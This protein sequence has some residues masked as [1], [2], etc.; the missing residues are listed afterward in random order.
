MTREASDREDLLREAKALVD[1]IKLVPIGGRPDEHVITG[2][3]NNGATS[4]CFGTDTV[5]HFSAGGQ[6]RRAHCNAILFKASNGKLV[7]S[8]S[9]W[10][11]GHNC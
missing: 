5:Y 7:S 3:R 8:V 4:F 1:R 9:G 2:F 10:K 11:I 6:L